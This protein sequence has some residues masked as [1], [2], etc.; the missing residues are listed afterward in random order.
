MFF[1]SLCHWF[2]L[3]S[4]AQNNSFAPELPRIKNEEQNTFF[5][6]Y[7]LDG[8]LILN[9]HTLYSITVAFKENTDVSR[10]KTHL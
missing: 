6:S 5:L 7:P 8:Y 10:V 3:D 2:Q 1:R 9:K 4:F